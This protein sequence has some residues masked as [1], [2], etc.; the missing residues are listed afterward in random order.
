MSITIA[1]AYRTLGLPESSTAHTYTAADIRQAYLRARGVAARDIPPHDGRVFERGA[2]LRAARDRL[3]LLR[4]GFLELLQAHA[5]DRQSECSELGLVAVEGEA[6]ADRYA[7]ERAG[8][9]VVLEYAKIGQ[10]LVVLKRELNRFYAG[11]LGPSLTVEPSVLHGCI[12][13]VPK[14]GRW[15]VQGPIDL[16]KTTEAKR[17]QALI[18]MFVTINAG[19]WNMG[20]KPVF[21]HKGLSLSD[22][23]QFMMTLVVREFEYQRD[24]VALAVSQEKLEAAGLKFASYHR[25]VASAKHFFERLRSNKIFTVLMLSL[26]IVTLGLAIAYGLWMPMLVIGGISGLLRFSHGIMNFLVAKMV[27]ARARTGEGVSN[28]TLR[29]LAR[30]STTLGVLGMIADVGLLV[31]GFIVLGPAAFFL[32]PMIPGTIMDIVY[33]GGVIAVLSGIVPAIIDR[34]TGARPALRIAETVA[35]TLDAWLRDPEKRQR[36]VDKVV[37]D[38]RAAVGLGE[39]DLRGDG[40]RE[41]PETPRGDHR[42]LPLY[43]QH[44]SSHGTPSPEESVVVEDLSTGEDL[45]ARRSRLGGSGYPQPALPYSDV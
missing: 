20:K 14:D 26:S 35:D 37:P 34:V 4:L 23:E 5:T 19:H 1:E 27:D 6:T 39:E 22:T 12:R 38:I 30:V 7:C 17:L 2:L 41:R 43:H 3:L 33:H 9:T 18:W 10:S 29:I 8:E 15:C 24:R 28:K 45:G 13:Y 36:L 25:W 32:Y 40:D 44:R 11:A 31:G 42:A 16:S 21:K